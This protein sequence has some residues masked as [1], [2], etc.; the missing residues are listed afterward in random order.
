MLGATKKVVCSVVHNIN[1]PDRVLR[2]NEKNEGNVIRDIGIGATAVRIATEGAARRLLFPPA[3][4]SLP[5]H[6][7][8]AS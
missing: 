4:F 5:E 2:P 6:H 8:M 1:V 3:P 7:N